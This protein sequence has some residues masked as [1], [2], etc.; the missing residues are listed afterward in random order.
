MKQWKLPENSSLDHYILMNKILCTTVGVWPIETNSSR[1]SR[2]FAYFRIILALT[3]VIS[4]FVPQIWAIA[5]NWGDLRV[6]TGVGCV[7]TTVSQYLFKMIYLLLRRKR[8]TILYYEARSFWNSSDDPKDRKI[9]EDFAHL[10]NIFTMSFSLAAMSNITTFTIAAAINS[11]KASQNVTTGGV[12][13]RQFP[14]EVWYGPNSYTSP[15]FEIAFVCQVFA[16][17]ISCA[18]IC[19]FDC[20]IMTLLLHICGQFKLIQAWLA[21]IGTNIRTQ[22]TQKKLLFQ[23]FETEIDKCIRHHRRI[24]NVVRETNS[25]LNP[26]IFVQLLTSG[27]E[28]CLSGYAVT[29]HAAGADLLK[30]TSYLVSMLIQLLLWCWPAELIIQES[31]KIG[32][33]VYFDIPWYE[34]SIPHQKIICFV[35]VRSQKHCNITALMLQTLS[36]STL[37]NVFNTAGSYFALLRKVQEN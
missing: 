9:L 4:V 35:I 20:T 26:I 12:T 13:S 37:T 30:F 34:L 3:A 23:M 6:F 19:G 5:V 33:S 27:L 2:L 15:I 14:F 11:V 28:I 24:I 22:L 16:A 25:L 36:I 17:L 32:H 18:G 29:A 8:I 10:A 7:F 1:I 31:Q 21:N